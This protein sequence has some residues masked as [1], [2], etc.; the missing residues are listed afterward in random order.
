M[1]TTTNRRA[2]RQAAT[3]L[4]STD[5]PDIVAEA[6]AEAD[7]PA[8]KPV[9]TIERELETV[10]KLESKSALIRRLHFKEGLSGVYYV[11]GE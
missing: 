1:S 2:R 7:A 6:P 5:Q 11:T 10:T 3:K 4:P 9:P 8:P